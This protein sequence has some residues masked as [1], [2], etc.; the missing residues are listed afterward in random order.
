MT[1]TMMIRTIITSSN[2]LSYHIQLLNSRHV[3]LTIYTGLHAESESA[4]RINQFLDPE[5][6]RQI[7]CL[8]NTAAEYGWEALR[9]LLKGPYKA[10]M[11]LLRAF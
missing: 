7:G 11:R 2:I 8:R 6:K 10:F 9:G 4:V 5:E 3:Q 1:V